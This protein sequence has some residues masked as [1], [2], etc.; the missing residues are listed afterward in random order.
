MFPQLT[1][2]HK[3]LKENPSDI[4]HF[5]RKLR[6]DSLSLTHNDDIQQLLGIEPVFWN[7]LSAGDKSAK[8][9]LDQVH[10]KPIAISNNIK[11]VTGL[12]LRIESKN[13]FNDFM[14]CV[15]PKHLVMIARAIE[16]FARSKKTTKFQFYSSVICGL[17]TVSP[18]GVPHRLLIRGTHYAHDAGGC[19]QVSLLTLDK[20]NFMMKSEDAWMRLTYGEANDKMF[21]FSTADQDATDLFSPRELEVLN[22]VA[23]GMDSKTIAEKLYV[24]VETVMRHRKNML[25]KSGLCDSTALL[26][27]CRAGI[28]S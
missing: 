19:P 28:L 1:N 9:V 15:A 20:I 12:D 18:D 24:S 7:F 22:G 25:A 5:L 26:Q 3:I 10:Y 23:Q 17:T 16:S 21:F 2:Y 27:I 11:S 4:A 14:A 13:A 6:H 8:V